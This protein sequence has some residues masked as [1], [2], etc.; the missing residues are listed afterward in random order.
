MGNQLEGNREEAI[1]FISEVFEESMSYAD[2]IDAY[3]K[4]I[5]YKYYWYAKEA[6]GGRSQYLKKKRFEYI[7]SLN[8][9]GQVWFCKF[10]M[11]DWD[12]SNFFDF[13]IDKYNK[14]K[15]K[16]LDLQ[17]TSFN[18]E[19]ELLK[20]LKIE[21]MKFIEDY[22]NIKTLEKWIID[23]PLKPLPEYL[24]KTPKHKIEFERIERELISEG[25]L[26]PTYRW[27]RQG[28]GANKML[29]YLLKLLCQNEI[30]NNFTTYKQG[31]AFNK[32]TPIIE[33]WQLDKQKTFIRDYLKR[34]SFI[35]STPSEVG[36]KLVDF[37]FLK[38]K[39]M[40]R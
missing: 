24:F 4:Y 26:D 38:L 5:H 23:T 2:K 27:D 33:R 16:K 31:V 8:Q 18:L 19:E 39:V 29:Q 25:Y 10:S 35:N 7:E 14:T 37:S 21:L 34:S 3:T 20:I 36:G 32:L 40:R 30:F 28:Y 13:L 9:I 15:D 12:D 22:Y 17:S 6:P 1:E 11:C